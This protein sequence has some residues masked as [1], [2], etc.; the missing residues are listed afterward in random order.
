[1]VGPDGRFRKL[2]TWRV[3]K[4]SDS[5]ADGD[6]RPGAG[7]GIGQVLVIMGGAAEMMAYGTAVWV[8]D[9]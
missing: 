8:E 3:G 2:E 5:R 1:M 6:S 4:M 9:A 7:T